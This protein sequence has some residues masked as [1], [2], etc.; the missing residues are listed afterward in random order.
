MYFTGKKNTLY[1]G[2]NKR[3]DNVL[4]KNLVT[5]DLQIGRIMY[6]YVRGTSSQVSI[7]VHYEKEDKYKT[8][9]VMDVGQ[10]ELDLFYVN[11]LAR[12]HKNA[13]FM[14]D[15]N[16]MVLSTDVENIGVSEFGA[17]VDENA[18]KLFRQISFYSLSEDLI[19]E[20]TR[21]VASEDLNI[22][23]LFKSQTEV[24]DI[25]DYSNILLDKNLE[26]NDEITEFLGLQKRGSE[27][28]AKSLLLSMENW[29][30]E[31]SKQFDL[32]EKD[33]Q[34]LITEYDQF[35][36]DTEFAKTNSVI[37][38]LNMKVGV[39]WEIFQNFRLHAD[40]I[41]FNLSYLSKKKK[42]LENFPELIEQYIQ[43]NLLQSTDSTNSVVLVMLLVLGVVV[44]IALWLILKRL[45]KGSNK[46]RSFAD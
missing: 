27:D 23:F 42:Y 28:Y 31:T 30:S 15:V 5:C 46:V 34:D 21:A 45:K 18:Q 8:C 38:K 36:L 12:S 40:Q 33:A 22:N 26:D 41:Q 39:N 35:D 43:G 7:S 6:F 24:M 10:G 19:K 3:T 32:M 9:A 37:T 16:S 14:V 44:I 29:M 17:G 25:L 4:I 1:L 13:S 11:F 2:Y 20:K